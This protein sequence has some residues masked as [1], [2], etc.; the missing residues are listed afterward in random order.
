[1]IDFS[2]RSE[3]LVKAAADPNTSVV[4]F[5][6][7]LGYGANMDPVGQLAPAL[8]EA[9]EMR[10]QQNRPITF[11][12]LGV[13]YCDRSARDAQTSGDARSAR[14]DIDVLQC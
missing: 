7:V 9:V 14:R 13:R 3:E 5:D 8:T 6:V 12:R 1:M 2:T 10:K 11:H 4:L